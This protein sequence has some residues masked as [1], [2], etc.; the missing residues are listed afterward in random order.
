MSH[1]VPVGMQKRVFR[2]CTIE[3]PEVDVTE[4]FSAP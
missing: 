4:L 1:V 2:S 3:V